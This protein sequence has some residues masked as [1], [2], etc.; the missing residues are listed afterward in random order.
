MLGIQNL[1]PTAAKHILYSTGQVGIIQRFPIQ[2]LNLWSKKKDA[3]ILIEYTRMQA[4]K[5]DVYIYIYIS[6]YLDR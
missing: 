5:T 6:I 2:Y 1:Q 3:I 4:T